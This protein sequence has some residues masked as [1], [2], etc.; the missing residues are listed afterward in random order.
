MSARSR[1]RKNKRRNIVP[2]WDL[3]VA[4]TNHAWSVYCKKTNN[5]SMM[6]SPRAN[7]RIYSMQAMLKALG[8]KPIPKTPPKEEPQRYASLISPQRQQESKTPQGIID[9]L[10]GTDP[11]ELV[12]VTVPEVQPRTATELLRERIRHERE[13]RLTLQDIETAQ[14]LLSTRKPFDDFYLKAPISVYELFE[15]YVTELPDGTWLPKPELRNASIEQ[16]KAPRNS[17]PFILATLAA[18]EYEECRTNLE[19]YGYVKIQ[20]QCNRLQF[21][22]G[23]PENILVKRYFLIVLEGKLKPNDPHGFTI[24]S[25]PSIVDLLMR[26]SY[27]EF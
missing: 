15:H 9:A 21:V 22:P 16:L 7:G 13:N 26:T 24:H 10:Y 20:T 8:H 5:Y 25:R 2:A 19:N 6:F 18:N 3:L 12:E 1:A 23:E 4:R 14:A 27:E 11:R 17:G